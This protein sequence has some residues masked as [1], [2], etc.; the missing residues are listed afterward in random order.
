M[1]EDSKKN[2]KEI[3]RILY[4]IGGNTSMKL[5]F[6]VDSVDQLFNN[7]RLF[8]ALVN[9]K[10]EEINKI[11]VSISQL[12]K[13]KLQLQEEYSKLEGFKESKRQRVRSMQGLRRVKLN[14]IKSINSDKKR[15]LQLRDELTY[16]ASRI[17]EVI[18][19]KRVKP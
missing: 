15:Y 11:K 13:V 7:Y 6:R 8:I 3:L 4:K 18:S 19:G 2:I 10:S 5:F 12:N 16:E 14:Y 9:Y 1:I 17:N